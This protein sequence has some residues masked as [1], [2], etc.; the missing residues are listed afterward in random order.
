MFLKKRW[1][2]FLHNKL[3]P[4]ISCRIIF[5]VREVSFSCVISF[6]GTGEKMFD[7]EKD[8]EK[9]KWSGLDFEDER[10]EE[11]SEGEVLGHEEENFLTG[12]N[13]FPE[14]GSR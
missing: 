6:L 11:A 5:F 7:E 3:F 2:N 13:Y 9:M 1:D 12:V 4:K 10:E 14:D 8:S